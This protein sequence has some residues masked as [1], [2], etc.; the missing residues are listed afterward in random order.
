VVE[1]WK[2]HHGDASVLD[3]TVKAGW[4]VRCHWFTSLS[5]VFPCVC[6]FVFLELDRLIYGQVYYTT[7]D[8]CLL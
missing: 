2:E 5:L 8:W 3:A 6:V 7:P 4:Q 1:L